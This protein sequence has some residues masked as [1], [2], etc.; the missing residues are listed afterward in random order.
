MILN[1]GI[2]GIERNFREF[3]ESHDCGSGRALG[4]DRSFQATVV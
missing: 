1:L 3:R 4:K 2:S